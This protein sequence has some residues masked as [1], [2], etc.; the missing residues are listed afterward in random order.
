MPPAPTRRPR[1]VA[2]QLQTAQL[3]S[4]GVQ[5]H[6]DADT[7]A[8]MYK[9]RSLSDDNGG[10]QTPRDRK[11]ARKLRLLCSDSLTAFGAYRLG[12]L[13]SVRA[14]ACVA[15]FRCSQRCGVA[16]V[17]DRGV[18]GGG[19]GSVRRAQV[20]RRSLLGRAD[21]VRR[22]RDAVRASPCKAACVAPPTLL[23]R[24]MSSYRST[25]WGSPRHPPSNPGKRGDVPCRSSGRGVG[26]R[27]GAGASG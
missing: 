3:A 13:W 10:R 16:P 14:K 19:C 24:R 4:K 27:L 26:V 18:C 17:F 15:S 20:P 5:L 1:A 23:E 8:R 25:D 21:S 7:G 9:L 2:A 11:E 6:T 12:C 22:Q